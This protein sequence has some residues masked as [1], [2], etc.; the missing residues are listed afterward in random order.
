[1]L[2]LFSLFLAVAIG[3]HLFKA[4]FKPKAAMISIILWLLSMTYMLEGG[5]LT[6]EYSLPFQFACIY[7]VWRIEST[8]RQHGRYFYIG[9]FSAILFF[10]KQNTIGILLSIILYL[11][12]SHMLDGRIR[13]LGKKL[14]FLFAG[15]LSFSILLFVLFLQWGALDALWDAAFVYNLHYATRPSLQDHAQSLFRGWLLLSNTCISAFG[16]LGWNMALASL[17]AIGVIN[18]PIEIALAA[19]GGRLI[20]HYYLTLLASFTLFT[21]F[22]FFILLTGFKNWRKETNLIRSAPTIFPLLIVLGVAI[23]SVKPI[24]DNFDSYARYRSYVDQISNIVDSVNENSFADDYVL[25][26][27]AETYVNFAARRKSPTKYVYQFPLRMPGYTSEKMVV[28]YL[29]DILTQRP[30]LIV[31]KTGRW[32][33]VEDFPAKSPQIAHLINEVN[34]QYLQRDVLGPWTIYQIIG[35]EHTLLFK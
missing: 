22:F 26:L 31:D 30:K 27:R 32:R 7:I 11:L 23:I 13:Q 3:F 18:L 33:S 2:E 6:T 19:L 16:I 24:L 35:E 12:I 21:A 10:L 9:I 15:L 25:A 20:N 1:M 17:L 4:S 8:N 29:Q 14:A 34:N 5:N 28:E